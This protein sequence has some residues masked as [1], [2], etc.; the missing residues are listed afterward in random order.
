MSSRTVPVV[1]RPQPGDAT[2][3]PRRLTERQRRALDRRD[4][5][6]SWVRGLLATI[7]GAL[8]AIATTLLAS[9]LSNV[10]VERQDRKEAYAAVMA[11]M[12][13]YDA[14]IRRCELVVQAHLPSIGVGFEEFKEWPKSPADWPDLGDLRS[15][16]DLVEVVGS[17]TTTR[18]A[19]DAEEAYDDAQTQCNYLERHSPDAWSDQEYYGGTFQLLDDIRFIK[20]DFGQAARKDLN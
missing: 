19:T 13:A 8:I 20:Q 1:P 17:P 5:W 14:P 6:E 7:V 3:G 10:Q 11:A 4:K 18:I 16:V 12:R 15:A 9:C 2:R